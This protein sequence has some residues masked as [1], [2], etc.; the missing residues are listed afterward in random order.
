MMVVSVGFMV[1]QAGGAR[2]GFIVGLTLAMLLL[3]PIIAYVIGLVSGYLTMWILYW[4]LKGSLPVMDCS[5]DNKPLSLTAGALVALIWALPWPHDFSEL[6]LWNVAFIF[7]GLAGNTLVGQA[8]AVL[9]LADRFRQ[10][11]DPASESSAFRFN[12]YGMLAVM[13]PICGVLSL[14]QVFNL[15]R[16][17]TLAIAGAWLV[18]QHFTRKPAVWLTLWWLRR[19]ESR[20]TKHE[21]LLPD[22]DPQVAVQ[23]STDEH[24][25]SPADHA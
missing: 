3:V 4:P 12:L 13:I 24:D 23:G 10:G 19:K 8:G 25:A 17:E 9:A 6:P 11:E 14:L 22:V 20:Q 2:T 16:I 7:I 21:G 5:P 18:L 1:Y 15:L